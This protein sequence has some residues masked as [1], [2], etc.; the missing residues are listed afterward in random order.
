MHQRMCKLK[1]KVKYQNVENKDGLL[2]RNK[3]QKLIKCN[4][5]ELNRIEKQYK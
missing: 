3:S 1:G 4:N 5:E 2:F